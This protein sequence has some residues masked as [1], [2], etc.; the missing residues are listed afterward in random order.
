MT[1]ELRGAAHAYI[2]RGWAVLLLAVDS[3]GGKVPPRNC[4]ECNF[5][6]PA[7]RKHLASE[8]DHLLCHG[9]YSAT[10]DHARFDRML[11]EL[12][13]G[14]LAIRTGRASELLVV[15]A[16]STAAEEGGPTGVQI[17]EEQWESW[18]G[19]W[20]LPA[21]L[22][23]RSVSGGVHL[24]YR[25]PA[26][27]EIG[28]GRILPQVDV[29]AE[30][31]YVG[32]VSGQTARTWIDPGREVADAPPELIEWL[33]KSKRM[34]TGGPGLGGG[35]VKPDGYDFHTF[36]REG[37]PD[38]HRDYFFNDLCFRL[39]KA[40]AARDSYEEQI[41]DSWERAAQPTN[42][43]LPARYEM[44]WEHVFYKLE[45]VWAQ[46]DPDSLAGQALGWATDIMKA[47]TER[48]EGAAGPPVG[49]A[50]T[51]DSG[52]SDDGNG[53]KPSPLVIGE[54]DP[55]RWYGTHDDGTAARIFDVWGDWFRAIPKQRGGYAWL[56]YNGV[57]WER[58]EHERIWPAVARVTELVQG[59]LT[60][61][62]VR[63]AQ[64]AAEGV[65]DWRTRQVGGNG[66]NAGEFELVVALRKYVAAC[67]ENARKESGVKAFARLEAIT[68]TEEDLDADTRYLGLPDG[69]VLDVGAVHANRDR[70]EWLLPADPTMLLTKQLGCGYVP[71]DNGVPGTVYE[72]SNFRRYLENVLP[73]K[74]VRETLQEFVGYAL[75]GDPTEKLIVLL[76][77][78][79]D[80][81]KT[82]LLQVLEA[83]F[84]DYGGWTDGQALIAGKAKS[85]HSEWLHKLRGLRLV[86]TPETAKGAKIDAA[87]MK[88]Y[89]GREPQTSRGVYGDRT[90]T[91]EPS[92]IIFN[93]SN[94]YLEYDAEDTAVAERTQVIEFER[95]FLRGDPKR[96]DQLPQKIR[97]G[98]L[99]IV[100][101]WALEGLRRH[102]ARR[103]PTEAAALKI[104]PKIAEW[105]KRYQVAQDHVGQFITDATGEGKLRLVPTA[106]AEAL[107]SS[108][109][110][111]A[112]VVYALYKAWCKVQEIRKPLGRNNFNAHLERVYRWR[113]VNSHGIRWVGVTSEITDD[114]SAELVRW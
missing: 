20:S 10:R 16:E 97:A 43:D 89:T 85:A 104:A 13:G 11:A 59:E 67:R 28:S 77:G 101:N 103:T 48:L 31:G 33:R 79:S 54:L 9:V 34:G 4:P 29:K 8:C 87:W 36:L 61:W 2:D 71:A 106:E 51:G 30:Y 81:G 56:R 39:R 21:T 55:E 90:V 100:L 111:T 25:I 19:G 91:W 44:P 41:R 63:C 3:S 26:D 46:V 113:N 110:V 107:A 66:Q 74:S 96:D 18:V 14:Q 40:G 45:R 57:T 32:A 35:G 98:E 6:D 12:P 112:K 27:V 82:V 49:T 70:S 88:S 58:D 38:G 99:P 73:D 24:F 22:A 69:R 47:A 94:H 72:L 114:L 52:G 60:R 105:S 23:S 78:P 84:G 86:L 17:I 80:S 53:V 15:D 95:Q 108:R 37:C 62:E 76:H 75:L 92:G 93:A 7:F 109:F 42:P 68:V 50:G 65:E 5:R 64:L 102:G 83:L 1:G